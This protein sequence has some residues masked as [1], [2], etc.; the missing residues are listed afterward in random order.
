MIDHPGHPYTAKLLGTVPAVGRGARDLV[1]IPGHVPSPAYVPPGCAFHDRCDRA[2]G[3]CEEVHPTALI[4]GPDH[5][6]LCHHT[7]CDQQ[8]TEAS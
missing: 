4:S 1:S 7:I 3:L 8:P 6:T 5:V 2:T